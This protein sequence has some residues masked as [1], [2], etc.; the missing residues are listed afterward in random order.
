MFSAGTKMEDT[1]LLVTDNYEFQYRGETLEIAIFGI[2][3]D[4]FSNAGNKSKK[5]PLRMFS[6]LKGFSLTEKKEACSY[7]FERRR[8]TLN[9]EKSY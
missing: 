2:S 8:R 9:V 7:G 6:R 3:E 5:L 1:K 4:Q